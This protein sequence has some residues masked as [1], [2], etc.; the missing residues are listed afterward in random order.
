M[1]PWG[2]ERMVGT[3]RFAHST[4]WN[5]I[6]FVPREFMTVGMSSRRVDWLR[7]VIGRLGLIRD[8]ISKTSPCCVSPAFYPQV[9]TDLG[10][11]GGKRV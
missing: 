8:R 11:G 10:K 9:R 7:R 5:D 2:Y 6:G 4:D 3:L 1:M